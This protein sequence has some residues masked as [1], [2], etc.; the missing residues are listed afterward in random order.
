MGL[1]MRKGARNCGDM[2]S[3]MARNLAQYLSQQGALDGL[4]HKLARAGKKKSS[5]MVSRRLYQK[6]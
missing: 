3:G 5:S 4:V 2:V 6:C 1:A